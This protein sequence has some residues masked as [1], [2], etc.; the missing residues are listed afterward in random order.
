MLHGEFEKEV[1]KL[2]VPKGKARLRRGS[3]VE[4]NKQKKNS[5]NISKL[6]NYEKSILNLDDELNN[7]DYKK[8][9]D[10][11]INEKP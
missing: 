6:K 2:D 11:N 7:S 1:D 5:S 8:R 9:F 10:Y 3:K 4:L